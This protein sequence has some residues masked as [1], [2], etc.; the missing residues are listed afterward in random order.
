MAS[1]TEF[2]VIH[3]QTLEE[4]YL[5]DESKSILE[6]DNLFPNFTIGTNWVTACYFLFAGYTLIIWLYIWNL[7]DE[8]SIDENC[9]KL[10]MFPPLMKRIK[11]EHS[12]G[13]QNRLA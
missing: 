5:D 6:P 11:L 8:L 13:G 9:V 1:P 12:L 2:V 4:P 3:S 10:E 7:A